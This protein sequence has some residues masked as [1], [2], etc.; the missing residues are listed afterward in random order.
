MASCLR[1]LG[2]EKGYDLLTW[3]PRTYD[4]QTVMTPIVEL[5]EGETATVSGTIRHVSEKIAGRRGISML[6]AMIDDGTGFLQVTWFNQK[7]LQKQLT[8]GKRLFLSGKIAY[9]YGGRGQLA[10]S[11]IASYQILEDSDKP[12]D[13][14]GIL[15]IYAT[16]ENLNQ[17]KFRKLI[18]Q[19]LADIGKIK[20]IFPDEICREHHLISREEAFHQIHFPSSLE[21]LK[22]ARKRLAFEELFLIQCGLMIL[23]KQNQEQQEGICHLANGALVTEVKS[24][25]PFHLTKD[26]ENTWLEICGDME[27]SIP[28]RR[29]VQGDVGSGKTV[30]AML[31]LVK[32]VENGF[33][34]AMMAPTEILAEQHYAAFS[35]SLAGMGIRVGFL[36]GKLTKKQKEAIYE[37]IA[38]HELDILVGTHALIQE[39][40]RFPQLGLV[41]TDEQHRFGVK[42]RQ[43][44]SEGNKNDI[45]S[46]YNTI[47]AEFCGKTLCFLSADKYISIYVDSKLIYSFGNDDQK[48]VGHTPG[49]VMVFADIPLDCAGEKI[50]INTHSPY[51]NYASYVTNMVVG[52]RDIC[53]LHFIKN[54]FS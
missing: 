39:G 43:K 7:F 16:T 11:Q 41:V 30:I 29:L 1:H 51:D 22:L 42:Q 14:C 31:A 37:K 15:P 3:Y 35:R 24:K 5:S 12:E 32:T 44:L 34:G 27:K 38:L 13:F 52:D 9:A 10:M 48:T 17:K 54:H 46:I 33:Q 8:V 26:Q 49:S 36:S 50:E 53:I 6:T 18:S 19:L 28:M 25:L 47:P 4:D 20:E 21:S 45:I 2:I 40:V 23:K